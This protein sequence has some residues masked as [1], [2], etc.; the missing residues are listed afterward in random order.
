[1]FVAQIL[2]IILIFPEGIVSRGLDNSHKIEKIKQHQL[3]HGV[4]FAPFLW[5][6]MPDGLTRAPIIHEN[7][8]FNDQGGLW[9]SKTKGGWE[10]GS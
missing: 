9:Q 8:N 5:T 1:M 7:F 3:K 10:G 2:R 6:S 4:D